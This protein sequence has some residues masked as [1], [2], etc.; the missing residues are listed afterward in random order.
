MAPRISTKQQTTNPLAQEQAKH[1]VEHKLQAQANAAIS[2]SVALDNL[3]KGMSKSGKNL[4]T[5]LTTLAGTVAA[6]LAKGEF[7]T[8]LEGEAENKKQ[9]TYGAFRILP[10]YLELYP[11]AEER[12][13]LPE[14][15]SEYVVGEGNGSNDMVDVVKWRPPGKKGY[16]SVS[17]YG[18]VLERLYPD[19]H[20]KLWGLEASTKKDG[21]Q[22]PE[23]FAE[24]TRKPQQTDML[25][26]MRQS[27][28]TRLNYLREAVA[29]DKIKR[30]IETE[31]PNLKVQYQ[32]GTNGHVAGKAPI[33][34]YDNN[35]IASAEAYTINSFVALRPSHMSESTVA[36]LKK[37]LPQRGSKD[38]DKRML[39]D[40]SDIVKAIHELSA[41]LQDQAVLASIRAEFRKPD[42][43][44]FIYD[45]G[46]LV[47]GVSVAF[48]GQ[49]ARYDDIC[50]ANAKAD[51]AE[52]EVKAKTKAA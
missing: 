50:A 42:A 19:L 41:Q 51:R 22:R 39:N 40:W 27:I 18:L 28:A 44:D 29:I 26:A 12:D 17:F 11:D 4:V 43:D 16:K 24:L 31:A 35:N 48:V 1:D 3:T 33:F 49:T 21:P 30:E 52:Q 38:T 20:K 46:R 10:L 5:N 25:A 37:T 45:F 23:E 9:S 13:T 7:A 2:Q 15:W 6:R 14:P 34:V 8:L 36:A 47:D 32:I